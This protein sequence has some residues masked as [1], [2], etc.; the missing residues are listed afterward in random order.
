M[1]AASAFA[2]SDDMNDK[3]S[4]E[5]ARAMLADIDQVA[6]RMRNALAAS[7]LGP[8]LAI[9]GLVWMAG[10]TCTYFWPDQP[11]RTWTSLLTAGMVFTVAYNIWLARQ[12]RVTSEAE[13]QL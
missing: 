10:F 5:E 3:L 8:N 12:K 1:R 2:W 7:S 11:V 9:W 13:K 6:K 4:P